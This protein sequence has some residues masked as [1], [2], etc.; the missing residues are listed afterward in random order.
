MHLHEVLMLSGFCKMAWY[1]PLLFVQSW[2]IFALIWGEIVWKVDQGTSLI[3][4]P[5]LQGR[6]LING[7]LLSSSISTEISFYWYETPAFSSCI[8]SLKSMTPNIT[9]PH[10]SF[11]WAVL[12]LVGEIKM[13][14]P[15]KFFFMGLKNIL[16][17]LSGPAALSLPRIYVVPRLLRIYWCI[18]YYISSYHI[19]SA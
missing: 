10:S 15:T 19:L 18:W 12:D 16:N 4:H 14:M 17:A 7:V 1:F 13:P 3:R 8:I 9:D 2:Y 11:Y 5:H 6:C